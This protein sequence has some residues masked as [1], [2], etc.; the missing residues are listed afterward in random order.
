MNTEKSSVLETDRLILRQWRDED[1]MP[2]AR[3]NADPRVMEFFPQPLSR[4]ESD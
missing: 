4:I 3:I 1:Y 2:F